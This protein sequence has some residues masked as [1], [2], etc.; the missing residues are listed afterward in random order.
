MVDSCMD[1]AA[2]K[3]GEEQ[4]CMKQTGTY[5]ALDQNGRAGYGSYMQ[6]PSQHWRHHYQSLYTYSIL[7]HQS[8]TLLLLDFL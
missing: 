6:G 3:R 1:C 2:C 7:Y 4:M 5:G 8:P